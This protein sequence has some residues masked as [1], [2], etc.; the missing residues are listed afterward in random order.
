M[1]SVIVA[2]VR[3]HNDLRT[4][5]QHSSRAVV[6]TTTE[7]RVNDYVEDIAYSTLICCTL[8]RVFVLLNTNR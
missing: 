2:V 6:L 8:V 4:V 3:E 1:C 5:L 7:H